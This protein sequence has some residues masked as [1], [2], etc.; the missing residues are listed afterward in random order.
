MV[1]FSKFHDAWRFSPNCAGPGDLFQTP[2]VSATMSN[3]DQP[4]SARAIVSIFFSLPSLHICSFL[5][6]STWI[7]NFFCLVHTGNFQRAERS[8]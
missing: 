2:S 1:T 5:C 4:S 8:S 6:L 7:D 3:Y